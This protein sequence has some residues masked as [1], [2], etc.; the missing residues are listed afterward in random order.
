MAD[1]KISQLTAATTP[2]AGTGT[3]SIQVGTYTRIGRRVFF[4]LHLS[5]SAHTGTGNLYFD[6]LP[7]SA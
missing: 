7:L 6:G 4:T 1:L 5:W 3:Y 2:L